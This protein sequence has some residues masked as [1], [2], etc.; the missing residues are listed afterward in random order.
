MVSEHGS[1][2]FQF[3]NSDSIYSD[4][5]I[6]NLDLLL[7]LL[8]P[9]LYRIIYFLMYNFCLT[10][11]SPKLLLELHIHLLF[12]RYMVKNV[13]ATDCVLKDKKIRRVFK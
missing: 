6:A 2:G 7:F 5:K 3:K 1:V 12:P 10:A 4:T 11:I 13:S 9:S 8:S